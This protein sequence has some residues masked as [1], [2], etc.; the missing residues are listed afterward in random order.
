VRPVRAA[1]CQHEEAP[2]KVL[3]A[4]FGFTVENIVATARIQLG[5]EHDT[6]PPGITLETSETA[7]A[8]AKGT[9]GS[10]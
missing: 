5:L 4:K 2:L 10:S 6:D 9:S 1:V 3:Q 7:E 8:Q